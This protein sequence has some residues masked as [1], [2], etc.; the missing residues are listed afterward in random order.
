MF[1]SDIADFYLEYLN[2]WLSVEAYAEYHDLSIE[3]T[4]TLLTL[5]RK[6][7]EERAGGV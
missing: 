2:D 3:D 4:Q 1:K 6:L 5:G 7:H